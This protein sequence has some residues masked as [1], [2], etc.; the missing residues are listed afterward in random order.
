MS[1]NKRMLFLSAIAKV[2]NFES[3]REVLAVLIPYN[4]IYAPVENVTLTS[5]LV[6][7][8]FPITDLPIQEM[9]LS[10][11]W[12]RGVWE[13][14]LI[15]IRSF[16]VQIGRYQLFEARFD[17]AISLSL[18]DL[19]VY[20]H[21]LINLESEIPDI[22]TEKPIIPSKAEEAQSRKVLENQY[23]LFGIFI[24]MLV[25]KRGENHPVFDKSHTYTF[26]NQA[27]LIAHIE[28]YDIYGLKKSTLEGRFH[29]ANL[30]LKEKMK[31]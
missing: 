28:M 12:S 23:A 26:K 6:S 25:D 10:I 8:D 9:Y 22:F 2:K 4:I 20:E 11:I 30:I 27:D 7:M 1:A 13:G 15:Q 31:T 3:A 14:N 21:D 16:D 24:D 29:R 18:E 19:F 17:E 5:P